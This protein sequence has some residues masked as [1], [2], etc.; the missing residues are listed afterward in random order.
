MVSD[1]QYNHSQVNKP[2]S[3]YNS[4]IA[5]IYYDETKIAVFNYTNENNNCLINNETVPIFGCAN[6]LYVYYNLATIIMILLSA[7]V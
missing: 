5:D 1:Q 2:P 3:G 6:V 7:H 4:C